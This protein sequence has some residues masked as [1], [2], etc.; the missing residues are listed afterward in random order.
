MTTLACHWLEG[1]DQEEI[2]FGTYYHLL[3]YPYTLG[4]QYALYKFIY[5]IGPQLQISIPVLLCDVILAK[6]FNL[7]K[8]IILSTKK[9]FGISNSKCYKD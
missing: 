8:P 5:F 7:S 2:D 9:R 1:C 4:H 3:P 6:L